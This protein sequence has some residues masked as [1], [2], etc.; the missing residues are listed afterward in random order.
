MRVNKI[1]DDSSQGD[2]S[3]DMMN[4]DIWLARVG[5]RGRIT[6]P[7]RIREILGVQPGDRFRVQ[8]REGHIFLVPVESSLRDFEGSVEP[9]ERPEDFDK[10]RRET[11]ERRSNRGRN[12]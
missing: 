3:S 12:D 5:S 8:G 7:K 2:G 4:N 10:V 9:R 11:K 1:R 6:I